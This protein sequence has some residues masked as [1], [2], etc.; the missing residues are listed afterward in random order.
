MKKKSFFV[1]MLAMGLA[2]GLVL[3]GCATRLGTFTV[4]STK[5]IDWSRASE[6]TRRNQWVDGQDICHIIIFFPT[7]FNVTVEDAV[8]NALEKV[9]GAVAL[10]DAV[11]RSKYF[12]I[13][14]IYGRSGF[15][16]E[17]T[18]LVDPKLAMIDEETTR[19]LAFYTEDGKDFKKKV[20][21]EAE[22]LSYVKLDASK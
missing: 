15:Y 20:L 2:F 16:I 22:Y 9:P 7:K 14:Y 4:I 13:P 21:S 10:I 3:T 5:T 11:L 19:Y 6:F 17:G 8:D 18:V 12:Y 1:A